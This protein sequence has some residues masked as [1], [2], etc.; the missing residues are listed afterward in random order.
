M[1]SKRRVPAFLATLLPMGIGIA[2]IIDYPYYLL[3]TWQIGTII[4]AIVIGIAYGIF[5]WDFERLTVKSKKKD[6]EMLNLVSIMAIL[7][8]I[9]KFFFR[10]YTYFFLHYFRVLRWEYF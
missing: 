8:F 1:N 2:M 3:T 9:I 6:K 4:I 5:F 10:E 7:L